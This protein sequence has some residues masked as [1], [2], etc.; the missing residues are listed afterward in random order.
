MIV[1]YGNVMQ[2]GSGDFIVIGNLWF[3]SKL[4][5]LEKSYFS[6]VL[7]EKSQNPSAPAGIF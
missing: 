2:A 1:K 6:E 7:V 3:V 4:Q 5:P